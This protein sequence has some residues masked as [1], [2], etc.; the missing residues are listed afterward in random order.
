[1]KKVM[2]VDDDEGMLVTVRRMLA[3]EG[4]DVITAV[5]GKECLDK[6]RRTIPDCLLID[7][8]MPEMDGWMLLREIRKVPMLRDVPVI[9]IT[10]K[11]AGPMVITQRRKS[12]LD[13]FDY[14]N[15]PFTKDE[16]IGA[17]RDACAE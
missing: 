3:P 14:I 15:K 17:L 13:F 6:L 9:I 4:Y 1:M 16:L 2:V 11:P 5:S 12:D 7:I 8:M 10:A